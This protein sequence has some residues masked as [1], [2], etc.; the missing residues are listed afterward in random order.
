M[1]ATVTGQAQ[2]MEMV[3]QRIVQLEQAHM[4]MKTELAPP[5]RRNHTLPLE[6]G[7]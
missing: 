5:P 3:R 7:K 2:E 1:N 4:K 6:N